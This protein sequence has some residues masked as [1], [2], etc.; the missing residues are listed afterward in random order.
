MMDLA[1]VKAIL[2]Y[3]FSTYLSDCSVALAGI[4]WMVHTLRIVVCM[5]VDAKA[6]SIN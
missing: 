1:F 6:P 4:S 2:L 5:A 3:S